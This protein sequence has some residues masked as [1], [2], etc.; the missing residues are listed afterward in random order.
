MQAI[1]DDRTNDRYD[2]KLSDVF[3]VGAMSYE[4]TCFE[5]PF[6]ERELIA[7]GP[8][9]VSILGRCQKAK[10]SPIITRF[11]QPMLEWEAKKRP[12]FEEINEKWF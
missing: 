10:I 9:K 5:I 6:T 3:S 7:D 4:L 2:G 1:G 11:L 8:P 12:S